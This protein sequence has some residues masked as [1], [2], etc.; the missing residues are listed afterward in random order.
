MLLKHLLII[1]SLITS[2]QLHNLESMMSAFHTMI[3]IQ[4]SVHINYF[5]DD[6]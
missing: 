2:T 5:D 3:I 4:F 6:N 1:G